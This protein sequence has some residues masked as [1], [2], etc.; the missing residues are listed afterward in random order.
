MKHIWL[1]GAAVVAAV[2]IGA[3]NFAAQAETCTVDGIEYTYQVLD[4]GTAEIG[5]MY[6]SS[7]IDQSTSGELKIPSSLDGLS[8]TSIGNLAFH[9]CTNLTSVVIPD[10]VTSIGGHAFQG[11]RALTSVTIPDSVTRIGDYAFSSCTGLTSVVI[12][13]SVTRIDFGAFNGCTSLVLIKI[14][15]SVTHVGGDAFKESGIYYAAASDFVIIDGWL[16]AVKGVGEIVKIPSTVRHITYG[17]FAGRL[18]LTSVTIPSSVKNIG[19]RAFYNCPNLSEVKLSEGLEI[20]GEHAFGSCESLKSIEVPSSVKV[21]KYGAF[22]D[23]S[24]L[25][26]VKLSEGLES[27]EGAAFVDCINEVTIPASVTNMSSGAFYPVEDLADNSYYSSFVSITFLGRPPITKGCVIESYYDGISSGVGYYP[28]A[29]EAE[30]K[31]ELDETGR[32]HG[33]M[34]YNEEWKQGSSDKGDGGS[35]AVAGDYGLAPSEDGAV[36]LS[37]AQVYN[38]CLYDGEG[39]AGT[40]QVKAAKQRGTT[41]KLVI[42]IQVAGEKKVVIRG[43]MVVEEGAFVGETSDGR[44][45]K[46]E[47]GANGM[48]GSFGEYMIDGA[49]DV[50]SSKAKEDKSAAAEV[51]GVLKENGAVMIAWEEEMGWSG[52]S[53]TVGNRGRTKVVGTLA[54]GT[55]VSVSVQMIVG[56]EWCVV[57]VVYVKKE[58]ELAFNVWLARDGSDAEVD[59]LGDDVIIGG[60]ESFD[61]EAVFYGSVELVDL[62]EDETYAEYFPDGM[63]ITASG[64][65]WILP[66][67]GKVALK[68][69]EVDESKLGEN[70]SGLKLAYR[71][72]DGT[73]SGSFKV[74]MDYRGKPRATVVSVAGVMIDGVGYGTATIRK[75]GSVPIAIE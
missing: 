53:V 19:E 28:K 17:V 60:A 11:C 21:I 58:V 44:E 29:Y 63:V 4:D 16:V 48:S 57:P 33:L 6:S 47:L 26:T 5:R 46:L 38:G 25:R 71:A 15:E 27:I 59:G 43:N 73:F 10:S 56:E 2:L 72:K 9:Y 49:R 51:L 37:A 62:L 14:P 55:K 66:R 45:L 20:I 23:C 41:S 8:V 74:Y 50:F 67:A 36:D 54:D 70:P 35:S 24:G 61:E 3:I 39:L 7:A 30:W 64:T 34:M 12:P 13:N 40:I 31:A 52:L 65:K 1:K 42:A 22:R 75:V 18:A 32:W 68:N 69:G